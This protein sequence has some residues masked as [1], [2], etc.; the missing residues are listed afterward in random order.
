MKVVERGSDF[1][2]RDSPGMHWLLAIIFVGIGAL[3]VLGPLGLASNAHTLRW[4]ER[5]LGVAMGGLGVAV[6][7]WLFARAP[8]SRLRLDRVTRRVEIVRRAPWGRQGLQVSVADVT[9]IRLVEKT[10]DEGG[11]VFQVHLVLR[12]GRS[13][14][15]SLLWAHGR[16]PITDVG[17][18]LAAALDV[19]YT[20]AP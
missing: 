12:E 16:E 7:L 13:V 19:A 6:G 5:V 17:R 3:F 14:P 15:V 4:W 18:R 10:D 8:S 11:A 20:P 9:A 1:E 2:I